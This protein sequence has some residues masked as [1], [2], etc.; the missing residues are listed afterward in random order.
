VVF[1]RFLVAFLALWLLGLGV[2]YVATRNRRYLR[3]AWLTLQ[4]AVLLAV[5]LMLL[6]LFE[7]VLLML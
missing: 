5:A 1:L 3:I 6:Y 7:R 4:I 2:A